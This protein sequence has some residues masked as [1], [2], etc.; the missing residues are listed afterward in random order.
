MSI[1][2]EAIYGKNTPSNVARQAITEGKYDAI[3]SLKD[4]VF[5]V[6]RKNRPANSKGAF[7]PDEFRASFADGIAS[8]SYF[9]LRFTGV[10]KF[11][12]GKINVDALRVLPMHIKKAQLPDM[13]LQTNPVT[14]G[15]GIPI[16]Y[17][18]ENSTSPLTIEI[19][20]SSNLW[21][22]EFFTTWQNYIIDYSTIGNR[23]TFSIAY[24]DDYVTDI[25]IDYYNEEGEITSTFLFQDVY[26]KT[27]TSV[28]LDW[29]AKDVLTFTVELSYSYWS[30]KSSTSGISK[31][32]FEKTS[33][34]TGILNAL[35]TIGIDK[36]NKGLDK[37]I[38]NIFK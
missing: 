36:I 7:S 9:Q 2:D 18:Y 35:K 3:Q 33:V 13:S 28:D 10:P 24:F 8:S 16:Q 31:T 6:K 15:G 25:E 22:R 34:S 20:A 37:T 11:M 32:V 1:I 19:V 17:P 14:F 12:T 29:S 27:M 26:P 5:G 38:S 30:I 23:P 21:E 4:A